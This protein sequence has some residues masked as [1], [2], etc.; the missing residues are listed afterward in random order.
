MKVVWLPAA[1]ANRDALIEYIAQENL[2]AAIK[3]DESI[4]KQTDQLVEH[5]EMGRLGRKRGTR[6]LVISQTN[7]VVV[8]RVK[9]KE[10]RVEIWRVLHTS[11]AWPA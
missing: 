11:Q 7:F 10:K 4:E 6:E 2:R 8:Y 3:Q 9:P 5:P 1:I